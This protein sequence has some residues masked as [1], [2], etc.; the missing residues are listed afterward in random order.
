[1]VLSFLKKHKKIF[2]KHKKQ[3]R[4]FKSFQHLSTLCPHSEIL[5]GNALKIH[6]CSLPFRGLVRPR[7][8]TQTKKEPP[9]LAV[10]KFSLN[11]V[12]L[13]GVHLREDCGLDGLL[14]ILGEE[15][16]VLPALELPVAGGVDSE[17]FGAPD[18]VK[19][20]VDFSADVAFGVAVECDFFDGQ[21]LGHVSTFLF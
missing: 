2:K 10:L 18:S 7:K 5:N 21:R 4:N 16:S 9:F 3:H 11:C 14:L 17:G 1:M 12:R 13:L 20:E 19:A 8:R 15:A 6:V